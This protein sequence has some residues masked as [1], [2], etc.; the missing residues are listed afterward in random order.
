MSASGLRGSRVDASRAGMRTV[1]FK[2]LTHLRRQ[3]AQ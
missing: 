3:V 1:K 2:G